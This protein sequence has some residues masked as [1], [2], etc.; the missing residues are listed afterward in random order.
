MSTEDL[1]RSQ[2]RGVELND[3][4][5][6]A[7][8]AGGLH[9]R[10]GFFQRFSIWIGAAPGRT[11]DTRNG[12]SQPT[13]RNSVSVGVAV[14]ARYRGGVTRSWRTCRPRSNGHGDRVTM[15][16]M[17]RGRGPSPLVVKLR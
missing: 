9:V 10:N 1:G 15:L 13:G 6:S 3:S 12:R 7:P 17:S 16:W 5:L 11:V 8:N 14:V 4:T 2:A